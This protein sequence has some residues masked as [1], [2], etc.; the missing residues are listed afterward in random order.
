MKDKVATVLSIVLAAIFIYL[1]ASKLTH[2]DDYYEAI[3]N[4]KL[5]SNE[6]AA[7]LTYFLPVVEILA[8]LTVISQRFKGGALIT[9]FSLLM[10]FETAL[11]CAYFRDL[12]ISCGCS[13]N[14]DVGGLLLPIFRNFALIAITS[15]LYWKNM[16]YTALAF[17][18]A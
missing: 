3:I 7:A 1:G 10:I 5:V 16:A 2:V 11:L 12:D 13:A 8:G 14:G 18:K 17:E 4:Y 15:F 9:I 6:F